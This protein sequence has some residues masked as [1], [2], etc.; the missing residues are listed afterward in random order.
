MHRG[1]TGLTADYHR[2]ATDQGAILD[3]REPPL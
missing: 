1:V 3:E 2:M